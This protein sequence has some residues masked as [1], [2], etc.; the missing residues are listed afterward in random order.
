M[1]PIS[2]IRVVQNSK[3]AQIKTMLDQEMLVTV[4][5]DDP[6]YFQGYITDNLETAQSEAGLTKEEVARLIRNAF[7]ISWARDESKAMHLRRLDD[8]VAADARRGGSDRTGSTTSSS[9][10]NM[11]SSAR[12][13]PGPQT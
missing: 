11:Y 5:S 2:N 6:A 3:A 1:C 7:T 10:A 9:A 12:T 8:Y 4:N 13:R